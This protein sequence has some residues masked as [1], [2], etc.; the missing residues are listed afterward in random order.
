MQSL[1]SLVQDV[2]VV[3]AKTFVVPV[4]CDPW[5]HTAR[6]LRYFAILIIIAGLKRSILF[7]SCLNT[8]REGEQAD[9]SADRYGLYHEH[10]GFVLL[11]DLLD[12]EQ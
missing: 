11:G 12:E 5:H 3:I 6:R 9:G 10:A 4:L 8:I 1:L 7:K 2:A